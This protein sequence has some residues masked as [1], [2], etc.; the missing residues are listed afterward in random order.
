MLGIIA[1]IIAIFDLSHLI[2]VDCSDMIRMSLSSCNVFNRVVI[3]WTIISYAISSPYAFGVVLEM[4]P[5]PLFF[6]TRTF[7][8]KRVISTTYS[9]VSINCLASGLAKALA[10]SGVIHS[11]R[12]TLLCGCR[13]RPPCSC[14][15]AFCEDCHSPSPYDGA[16]RMVN[17]HCYDC[18]SDLG[19]C[20]CSSCEIVS[21]NDLG[22]DNVHL[23]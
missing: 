22:N 2:H 21:K 3:T 17:V 20:H 6:Q 19:F 7:R 9:P 15:Q 11:S 1:F 18:V 16:Q 4:R 8:I 13:F 23:C 14:Q 5:I 10:S 12:R